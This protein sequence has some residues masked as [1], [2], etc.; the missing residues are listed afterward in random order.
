M[1][2]YREKPFLKRL[3]L[4]PIYFLPILMGL[5]SSYQI[6]PL[7][8][9]L[10]SIL[11][12][13]S[14]CWSY[15]ARIL[16]SLKEAKK[17]PTLILY[18][19]K[20]CEIRNGTFEWN[21]TK[22][23]V[24]GTRLSP[25]ISKNFG[26]FKKH[27]EPLVDPNLLA[28]YNK[29]YFKIES[30]SFTKLFAQHAVSPFFVFQIFCGI[31]W[32]LDEYVYQ[33][34]FTI[35]M[36]FLIEAGL[37]FQRIINF[38]QFRT[39]NHSSIKIQMED[40]AE[41]DSLDLYPGD[42]IKISEN[43]RLPCDVLLLKGSCAVN[44][45]MLSGESVPLTKEDIQ[46]VEDSRILD[47][48]KDKKH[49]LFAGTDIVKIERNILAYVLYT[50]FDTQ[51]GELIKKMMSSE[52]VSVNDKEAFG[53]I[54]L[55]LAFAVVAGGYT[56]REGLRMG[57]SAY[58]IFLEVIL[59]I[60]N[61]VPT[62]LPLELSMAVNSCVKSLMD[63]GVFC[64]EPF[65]IPL[66][67]KVE[68]CCFDKTGTLTETRMEVN[69]VKHA[70]RFTVDILRN[71][72]TL[73]A[74]EGKLTGDPLEIGVNQ[75]LTSI[76]LSKD[77]D[78]CEDSCKDACSK[79]H[80]QN[81]EEDGGKSTQI[82]K[83]SINFFDSVR[84]SLHTQYSILKKYLFSSEIKRMTVVGESNKNVFVA[85]KGAPE[86]VQD[87]L[88]VIPESY[89]DYKK[90]AEDGFR[91]IALAYKPYSKKTVWDRSDVEKD[92]I[93]S[94]FV[95]FRC[96]LKENARET[97]RDLKES[98]HRVVMITGDNLLTAQ[99]VA[100]QLGIEGKG[101]EGESIDQALKEHFL[102]YSIFARADPN[103]KEAILA[104]YN[105]LGMH[106]L[107]CGDGT[108][109]V[110]ALKTAHIGVA[111]VEASSKKNT[112]SD[113]SSTYITPQQKIL[114]RLEQELNEAT[115]VKMGDASVA[116][117]FT[118]KTGSLESI[119][120]I[121]R[122]GRSALVTTIQMYKILGLNALVNAFSLSVLDCMG[123]RFGEVQLVAAGI[124]V[125]FAFMFLTASQPLKEISKK[126]PLSN[127]F[128]P[129][130]LL[131]VALQVSVHIASYFVVLR[132]IKPSSDTFEDK[133]KPSL[134]NTSLFYLSTAQQLSTFLV[135]Y[136]GRPFRESL[137]ENKKLSGCLLA[138]FAFILYL[139][140]EI[141]TD[142]NNMMEVVSLGDLKSFLLYVIGTDILL[143]FVLEKLCFYAF[144]L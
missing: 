27:S 39:M 62:E 56:W 24:D 140:F 112:S 85:M 67:G 26:F 86:V 48:Q 138:L 88:K 54:A 144:L 129:Y 19:E 35:V 121:I 7:F 58:K 12:W 127:I 40:G 9:V 108:N 94:G 44:E 81:N 23:L 16:L 97:I 96:R 15:K 41:R 1:N 92:L 70:N 109:D 43:I 136:I 83:D 124:L 79:N 20:L 37:V 102:E 118:A 95:L 64:L 61:V 28:K 51:Q 45:A 135:N 6:V 50:G 25:N 130:I 90:Y 75:Y 55:L 89:S 98:G 68:V 49:V 125:A 84:N 101:V 143:C 100:N 46:D 131:S 69:D 128:N 132:R 71:C 38:K 110:G 29:N 120:D 73:I 126:R 142:F 47:I 106:T 107:M 32:C 141:N 122:Q 36:L 137:L 31:L 72:H 30:P 65:R 60:T 116:A 22:F 77:E 103:H 34:I 53:F 13:L 82:T 78:A 8:T 91:V 3:F 14:T 42:V 104:L 11:L 21:K 114:R 133:F 33:A 5:T 113:T 134:L 18:K 87:F 99:S 10:L 117:P 74:I 2:L 119:L 139:I 111:L 115:S 17:R 4:I 76:F 63:R 80:V 57:K 66:A 52:E 93:F 59:I 123:I 105:K